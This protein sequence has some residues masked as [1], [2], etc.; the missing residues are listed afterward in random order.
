MIKIQIRTF[1]WQRDDL[2]DGRENAA[3]ISAQSLKRQRE[4]FRIL[5]RACDQNG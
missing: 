5:F 4:A 3:H 2:H 1:E